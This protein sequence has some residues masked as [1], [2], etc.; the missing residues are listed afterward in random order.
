MQGFL[1]VCIGGVLFYYVHFRLH[2]QAAQHRNNPTLF[3]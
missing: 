2:E 3:D 1:L